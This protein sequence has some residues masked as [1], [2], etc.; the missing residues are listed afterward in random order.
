MNMSNPIFSR[1]L[2]AP[3]HGGFRMDDY[4]IWCGSVVKGEDGR[5]HMFASRWRRELG[6][7]PQWLFNCEIVR[8]VSDDPIGPYTFAEVVFQRRERHYFDALNQHN[9][10]IK[11]WNGTYYLYYF[12]TTY[13]GPIPGPGDAVPS[14]RFLEV[15][16]NKRI[17]VATSRS[18]FGPWQRP[19]VPTLEPRRPGHWDC[20]ITTN[21][22]AAILPD[23][24]TYLIYKSREYA[25]STLKLGIAKAPTPAGPFS[26]ISEDPSFN[27]ANPDLHVEDPFIWYDRGLFHVVM[28]DDFKNDCGGL[29]GE[30][31]AGVYATSRD[32]MDWTLHP[33]PKA[34]PRSVRWDDGTV[35]RPCNLE[36]PNFLIE[37]GKP[38]HLFLATGNGSVPYRFDGVSWNMVIPLAPA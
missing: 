27:F 38:T 24:T 28:K 4:F 13:G 19:D 6:F 3:R 26:R 30:W 32:C 10:S 8:A 1:I 29:T 23:G 37:D 14:E 35:T 33:E 16:N 17:G 25:Y 15:W 20:T 21:P 31:G 2:P 36:R 7:N 22:S 34:Y 12:G 5:Y 18:V 11:F 9:P